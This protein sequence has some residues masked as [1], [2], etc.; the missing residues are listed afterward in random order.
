MR[1]SRGRHDV[2]LDH[3]RAHVV[4]AEP[5]RDLTDLHPLCDPRRLDVIDVVEVDARDR[6]REEIVER[7]RHL[8]AW[9]LVG[10][11]VA[12]VLERPGDEGA[13][14]VCLVLQLADAPHVLGALRDRLDVAVHHRRG[15]R[16]AQ[17][18]GMTHHVQPLVGL[19]L[20]RRDDLTHAVDE[21]LAAAPRQRV[22]A[23]VA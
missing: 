13:E 18:V 8:F 12:V 10:E 21:D 3:H 17:A 19:R 11:P 6:L 4:R 1:R 5:E 7:G 14:A 16:H 22:E 23:G 15:R 9:H 2:L 20:L